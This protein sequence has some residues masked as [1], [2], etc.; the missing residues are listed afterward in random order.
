M[1]QAISHT[2]LQG[3]STEE[4]AKTKSAYEGFLGE[5]SNLKAVREAQKVSVCVVLVSSES[6]KRSADTIS[7]CGRDKV[8][9]PMIQVCQSMHC[10]AYQICS[11]FMCAQAEGLTEEQAKVLAIMEKTFLCYITEDPKAKVH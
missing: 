7:W 4:L 11:F 2:F 5:P 10:S 8:G 6:G 1:H 9:G 3:A